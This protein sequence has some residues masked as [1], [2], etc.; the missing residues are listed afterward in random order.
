MGFGE[1]DG[2]MLVTVPNVLTL[3]RIFSI[4]V[5]VVLFYIDTPWAAWTALGLYA[6]A[7]FT[8]YLDGYLARRWDQISA[9]GRFL[10][11]VSDKIF[12]ATILVL[13]VGFDRL[14]GLWMIPAIIIMIREFTI[15][16][17]REFLGA[18]HVSV[19]VTRLAKWKTA[20]QM[21]ALGF[22]VIGP[23]AQ[24]LFP[25]TMTAGQW[26]LGI[27]AVLTV[28]TGWEYLKV[29]LSHIRTMT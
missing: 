20:L 18:A 12:V 16:G 15:S 13:L 19:P 24:N 25:P 11:P 7:A 27:A 10:D 29:G 22:L 6:L 17:L 2:G 8:D 28:V 1:N 26:G 4:P 5:L 9:F 14:P 23:Y 3:S 21:V